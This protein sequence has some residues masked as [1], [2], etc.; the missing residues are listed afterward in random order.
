MA[1]TSESRI[2][3]DSSFP[4]KRESLLS[5]HLCGLW[6]P[7]CAGATVFRG[8]HY[9]AATSMRL[10]GAE[11]IPQSPPKPKLETRREIDERLHPNSDIQIYYCIRPV[12]DLCDCCK[13][14]EVKMQSQTWIG[15]SEYLF[16][17]PFLTCATLPKQTW[18]QILLPFDTIRALQ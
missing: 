18:S 14:P 6:T 2:T 15:D 9:F 17:L 13:I 16:T 1:N 8:S 4:R 5:H 12:A 3:A 10:S 11:I 7:A